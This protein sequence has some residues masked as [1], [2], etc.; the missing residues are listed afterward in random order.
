MSPCRR[1]SKKD[2]VNVIQT[3]LCVRRAAVVRKKNAVPPW[4]KLVDMFP[5]RRS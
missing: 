4:F 2:V 3:Y 1:G 5:C